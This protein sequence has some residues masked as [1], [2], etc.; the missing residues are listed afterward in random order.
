VSNT[1]TITTGMF[2]IVTIAR[3]WRVFIPSV[4]ARS[5]IQRRFCV[6]GIV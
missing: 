6:D 3:L 2:V 5:S 4:C 1:H